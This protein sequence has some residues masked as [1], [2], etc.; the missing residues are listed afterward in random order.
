MNIITKKAFEEF[1]ITIDFEDRFEIFE[2]IASFSVVC[3]NLCTG[4]DESSSL[5]FYE[6]SVYQAID[7]AYGEGRYGGVPDNAKSSVTFGIRNGVV[8]NKYKITAKVVTNIG[9]TY[10]E[11]IVLEIRETVEGYFPKQPYESFSILVD[12]IHRLNNDDIRYDDTV[13]SQVV[14]V[15]RK[16]DGVDV[17]G[18]IVFASGLEGSEKVKIGI[19]AGDNARFY[20]ITNK[21][22][23]TQGYKYQMDILMDVNEK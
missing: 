20:Q 10:E 17:T 6:D 1:L 8:G 16:L 22:V 21:I 23:S 4:I 19:K 9:N 13:S 3:V 15:K 7:V 18:D 2:T 11:D 12:F 5:L 14:T